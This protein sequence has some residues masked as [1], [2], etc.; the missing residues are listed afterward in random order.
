MAQIL[1]A[2]SFP[3]L[4]L[5]ALD[6][7]KM[8]VHERLEGIFPVSTVIQAIQTQMQMLEPRLVGVRTERYPFHSNVNR[9]EREQARLIREQQDKAY[10][11][12]LEADREKVF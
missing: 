5:V 4:A 12:S 1:S 7:S 6:G 2:T 9:R 3:F 10:S 8:L 11:A